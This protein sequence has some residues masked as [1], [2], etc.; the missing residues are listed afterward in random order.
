VKLGFQLASRFL[1]SPDGLAIQA[2]Y[3][4]EQ[5]DTVTEPLSLG[6][7]NNERIRGEPM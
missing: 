6:T 3:C 7:R 4:L 1:H 2:G 5:L